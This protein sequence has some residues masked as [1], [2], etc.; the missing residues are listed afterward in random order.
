MQTLIDDIRARAP[1]NIIIVPSLNG[2]QSLAGRMPVLDPAHRS[3]PQLAYGLHYP[4]LTRGITFW[5]RTFGTAS[6]SIPVIVTEWDANSVTGC[7]P[8]APATAQ[9]LLDYLASKG[10]GV[11]GFAFDL[12]GTIVVD[13][14]LHAHQ[15]RGVRLRSAR[16]RPRP[17]PLRGLRSRGASG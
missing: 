15:L 5:D 9:V 6:A 10:I 4:S 11:V 1:Q 2:E 17:D 16:R 8:N 7:V 3:D 14:H 12:P 13:F